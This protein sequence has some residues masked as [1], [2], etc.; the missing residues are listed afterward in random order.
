MICSPNNPTGAVLTADETEAVLQAARRVGAWV[1][2]DEIYRG[3]ELSGDTTPTLWGRYEKLVVT[4]GLSKAFGLPGLRLG[5][6]V[7]PSDFIPELWKHRDYS[8][9]MVSRLSDRLGSIA[10]QP[11]RREIILERTREIIRSQLPLLDTWVKS[12]A[13]HLSYVAPLAGAIAYIDYELPIEST[14]LVEKL[15]IDRSVLVVAGDQVGLGRGFRIGFGYDP[16]K[17]ERGLALVGEALDEL[18]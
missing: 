6:I 14:T 16:E 3:A 4:S 10:L 7:A 8:T 1:L 5:W 15:R 13:D 12:R 11:A 18:R 17:L 9:L 2:S